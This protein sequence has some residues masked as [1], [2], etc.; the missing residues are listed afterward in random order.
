MTLTYIL[1]DGN[2]FCHLRLQDARTR[3]DQG[4]LCAKGAGIGNGHVFPAGPL[5]EEANDALKR[6]QAVILT[7]RGHAGDGI[8]AR[9]QARGIPVYRSMAKP[10]SLDPALDDVR[11]LAFS[12]IARPEKFYETLRGLGAE[13]AATQ[14]FP[15][16]HV[17]T[18]AEASRLMIRA[19]EL[20][21]HPVTTEKDAIR[22][23]HA[24]TGSARAKLAESL[25]T[26]PIRAVISDMT[27]LEALI[28]EVL[29]RHRLA[30]D[31]AG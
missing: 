30:R 18:E 3:E 19:R 27:Q 15:D 17:F 31:E 23:A 8:A 2:H 9:A 5:R 29:H 22:L 28:G 1:W 25:Q 6:I 10:T 24:P 4:G 11:V 26:V 14:D 21:A 13:V 12:G 7:G 16:H 20:D